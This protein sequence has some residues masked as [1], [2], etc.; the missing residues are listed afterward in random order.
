MY[1][2]TFNFTKNIF[3][4]CNEAWVKFLSALSG[5]FIMLWMDSRSFCPTY[6]VVLLLNKKKKTVL[7]LPVIQ[8]FPKNIAHLKKSDKFIRI[9]LSDECPVLAKKALRIVI[10]FATSYLY[11]SGFYAMAVI[12]AKYQPR[13][14]LER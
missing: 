13:L 11:Q 14:N 10:P 6:T 12:K 2:A 1:D 5:E 4:A 9:S 7:T 3:A 8:Y